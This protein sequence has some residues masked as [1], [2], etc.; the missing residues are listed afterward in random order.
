LWKGGEGVQK[1]QQGGKGIRVK[2]MILREKK[3]NKNA[4]KLKQ[5]DN[6]GKRG[7]IHAREKG[8]S[9]GKKGGGTYS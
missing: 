3:K 8:E 7:D 6:Q 9:V 5:E 1:S 2:Y 4:Q